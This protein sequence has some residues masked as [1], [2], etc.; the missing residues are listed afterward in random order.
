MEDQYSC[1]LTMDKYNLVF[2]FFFFAKTNEHV[3]CQS[4]LVILIYF[5]H[6]QRR[7]RN[8]HRS[9]STRIFSKKNIAD[10]SLGFAERRME[11]T[12]TFAESILNEVMFP[13]P[14]LVLVEHVDDLNGLICMDDVETRRIRQR[15]SLPRVAGEGIRAR[16]HSQMCSRVSLSENPNEIIASRNEGSLS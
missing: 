4:H 15:S 2:F 1:H 14:L 10:L 3:V 6:R 12:F 16:C 7:R 11:A 13:L 9:T 8:D 5:D